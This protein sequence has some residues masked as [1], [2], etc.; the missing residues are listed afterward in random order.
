[1]QYYWRQAMP[2]AKAGEAAILQQNTDRQAAIVNLVRDARKEYGDSL[3]AAMKDG[4]SWRR[5]IRK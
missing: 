2:Y 5:L 1:V 3:A 4:A